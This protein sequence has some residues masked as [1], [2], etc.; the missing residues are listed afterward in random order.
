MAKQGQFVLVIRATGNQWSGRDPVTSLH[1][2]RD[3]AQVELIDFV[4]RN[5]EDTDEDKM[6]DDPV[7]M[8]DLFFELVDMQY[9]ILWAN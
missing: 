2:T 8:I 3:E 5:W 7:E 4:K 6:P 9:E 1:A